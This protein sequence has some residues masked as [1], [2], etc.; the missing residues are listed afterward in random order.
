MMACTWPLGT[1]RL[2]PLRISRSPMRTCR[3]RI[4]SIAV[5]ILLSALLAYKLD[6]DGKSRL[7]PGAVRGYGPG[8]A[9]HRQGEA[10][11]V[12]EGQPGG[13]RC[14]AQSRH[15]VGGALVEGHDF[16]RQQFQ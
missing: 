7:F 3:S 12:A 2:T 1:V 15:L 13:A 9:A 14:P 16:D 5:V 4:S 10:G 6:V 8:V 11:P